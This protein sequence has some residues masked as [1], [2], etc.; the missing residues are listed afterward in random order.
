MG[1][2]ATRRA[3]R[4][5]TQARG[6]FN[7][8]PPVGAGAT[9]AGYGLRVALGVSILTRPWGRVQ[10]RLYRASR[11][12]SCGFNPHPPVG[13]GATWAAGVA[14][15]PCGVVSILTRP[16][17]RVQPRKPTHPRPPNRVSIL[18]RPWG[19]VQRATVSS[20]LSRC[21]CFNPH[22]PVGAGATCGTCGLMGG[23]SFQ[24]SPARGGGCNAAWRTR[25]SGSPS[26]S[27]PVVKVCRA[28]LWAAN[29]WAFAYGHKVCS[30]TPLG[31]LP[32]CTE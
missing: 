13:A 24:S 12:R 28:A 32:T 2:G 4:V 1:A 15:L 17:G 5:G 31:G 16:W 20:T 10:R 27:V 7:P 9:L 19:R 21:I 23:T 3:V 22:P 18:T 26:A 29:G 8:H 30:V 11:A 6:R 14:H 25:G